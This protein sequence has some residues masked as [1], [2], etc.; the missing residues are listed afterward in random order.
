MPEPSREDPGN[1]APMGLLQPASGSRRSQPPWDPGTQ[2]GDDPR[3]PRTH[4]PGMI[5]GMPPPIPWDP[6]VSQAVRAG[7]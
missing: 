4:L 2:R 7:G 3:D 5:P 1:P 6:R